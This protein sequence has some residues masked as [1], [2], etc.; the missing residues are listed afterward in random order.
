MQDSRSGLIMGD[1]RIQGFPFAVLASRDLSEYPI[2]FWMVYCSLDLNR[3]PSTS[4]LALV[5]RTLILIIDLDA[6]AFSRRLPRHLQ[7]VLVFPRRQERWEIPH[8]FC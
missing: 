5:S 4:P 7:G 6:Q 3:D 2:F 8:L 1:F